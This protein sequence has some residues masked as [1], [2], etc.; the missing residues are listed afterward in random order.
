MFYRALNRL[1]IWNKYPLPL[2]SEL[3]DKTRGGKW[4]T[5]LDLN[6]GINL[7]RVA[8]GH[9]WKT[10]FRTRRGLFR[11]TMMLL[12]LT[13]ARATFQEIMYTIC[14][15]EEDRVW[16]IHD[17][18]INGAETGA[19]NQADVE[20]SLQQCVNHGLAVNLTKTE[21]YVHET[22]FLGH[23]LNCS[24]VQMDPA[25]LEIMYKWPVP[26]KQKEV[27][28]F[29]GLRNYDSRFIKNDTAKARPIIDLIIHVPFSWGHQQQQAFDELSTRFLCTPYSHTVRSY[30]YPYY[31]N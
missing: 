24:Q 30:S 3:L 19:E 27:Q 7:I 2:I 21:F 16:Y 9:E 31:G 17:M 26:T 29:L 28:A 20:K 25:K 23:I 12:G 13:N 14:N 5:R 18:H 6:N 22:I 8:A 1:T 10:A 4:F 11:Y 15:D